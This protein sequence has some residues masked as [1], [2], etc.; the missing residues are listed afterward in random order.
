[1]DAC[2][3]VLVLLFSPA[4]QSTVCGWDTLELTR[5]RGLWSWRDALAAVFEGD[6]E[7][8]ELATHLSPQMLTPFAGRKAIIEQT[9]ETIQIIRR[10]TYSRNI[11]FPVL[12]PVVSGGNIEQ[13]TSNFLSLIL[14]R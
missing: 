10:P 3:A 4:W 5:Q 13:T 7:G 9:Q 2:R 6:S 14:Q 12:Q 11:H 8:V 1:M